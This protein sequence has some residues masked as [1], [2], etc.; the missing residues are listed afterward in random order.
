M[1]RARPQQQCAV[2]VEEQEQGFILAAR[3]TVHRSGGR[4]TNRAW[5]PINRLS[6]DDSALRSRARVK[7]RAAAARLGSET[8]DT[9]IEV[10]VA[11]LLV[12]L[13]A[14]AVFTGFTAVADISGSQRHES[15]AV[16]LAQQD[17]QRLRSLS[18]S[19][20]IANEPAGSTLLSAAEN[21]GNASYTE[22]LNN[23]VYTVTSTSKFVSA[24]SG[25]LSCTTSGAGSADFVATTSTVTWGTNNDGL[26]P[27]IDH[28]LITPTTDGEIVVSVDDTTQT[29]PAGVPGASIT[30]TGPGSNTT[31]QTESTDSNGCT[32][33]AGL[34]A[35]NYS[36]QLASLPSGYVT[37]GSTSTS[38]TVAI[39]NSVTKAFN[40][41]QAA[42]INATFQT[43]VGGTG[44]SAIPFD[45]FSAAENGITGSYGTTGSFASTVSSGATLYPYSS[46]YN[47]WAGNCQADQPTGAT[48]DTG[49]YGV[50]PTEGG[51][52]SAALTVP[53]M[54]F[55]LTD[56]YSVA[57]GY[58]YTNDYPSSTS[59]SPTNPLLVYTGSGW[60]HVT[61]Q[62]NDY[63]T[64]ETDSSTAGNY[65]K[66]TFTGTGVEWV[67]TQTPSSGYAN[68]TVTN[69][70]GTVV[71]SA[72]DVNTFNQGNNQYQQN[73]WSDSGL[74]YGT[75]TIEV[76]VDGQHYPG[77]GG[78]H[79]TQGSNGNT[80][81]ID[82]FIVTVPASTTTA[83][84]NSS[85]LP[86]TVTTYDSCPTPTNGVNRTLPWAP[87][88]TTV[89]S[90]SV[91]PVPIPYGTSDQVCFA[92]T[93]GGSTTNTGLLPSSGSQFS[94]TDMTGSTITSLT[95]PTATSATGS[96]AVFANSGACP[97]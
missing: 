73:Q 15:V 64:D 75:Y 4:S 56:S 28:S 1:G 14:A 85:T 49:T 5:A 11:A 52:S 91:Y 60:S 77:S 24:S 18:I 43:Y 32:T 83:A 71:S 86:Y 7:A 46:G 34:A 72:T 12:A 59:G 36:V 26:T 2:D 58:A 96:S 40:A 13:I 79:G 88:L 17:Q 42:T 57:A 51:T 3:Q 68:V 27:V 37:E 48:S 90:T 41:A 9:M 33:F 25:N 84:V 16:Q 31:Q 35:G 69:A 29:L 67:G 53:S 81:S 23:V 45:T 38:L 65:V 80:I 89:H 92:N 62:S 95:L 70:L 6:M 44:P 20:L 19:Q 10:V 39:G 93:I 30:I 55:N 8:G 63:N 74:T 82:E 21:Y 76:Y 54:L 78:M 61:G 22:T 47:V 94:D 87:V 97:T 50:V 66:F